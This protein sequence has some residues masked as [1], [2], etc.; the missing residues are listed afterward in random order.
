MTYIHGFKLR[1][2]VQTDASLQPVLDAYE[3]WQAASEAVAGRTRA[4]V[5]ALTALLETYKAT[6]EPILDSRANSA[7][8]VLQSSIIEEFFQY[9]FRFVSRDVAA[10]LELG[11]AA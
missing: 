6:A 7:Q 9:L 1:R 4:D 2:K 11:P 5:A 3:V 10:G 8:E